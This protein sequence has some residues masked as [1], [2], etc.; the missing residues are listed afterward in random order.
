M[1]HNP[2]RSCA[3]HIL[4]LRASGIFNKTSIYDHKNRMGA[5]KSDMTILK[6]IEL[7]VA[8]VAFHG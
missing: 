6:I 2:S 1:D 5:Y 8:S 3:N 7:A 4:A